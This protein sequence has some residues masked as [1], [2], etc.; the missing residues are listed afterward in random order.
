MVHT[1]LIYFSPRA[2]HLCCREEGWADEAVF[3]I[4][5]SPLLWSRVL[6]PRVP[7]TDTYLVLAHT[8]ATGWVGSDCYRCGPITAQPG[9]PCSPLTLI[10]LS[11]RSSYITLPTASDQVSALPASLFYQQV[12]MFST[13]SLRIT[14]LKGL[15]YPQLMLIREGSQN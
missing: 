12:I 4:C 11:T 14:L 3:L 15:C 7:S 1:I 13:H 10:E 8:P 5:F 6:L 9:F 2:K